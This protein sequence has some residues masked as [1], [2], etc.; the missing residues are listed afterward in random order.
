MSNTRQHPRSFGG[1]VGLNDELVQGSANQRVPLEWNVLLSGSSVGS[2]DG[3]NRQG[4]PFVCPHRLESREWKCIQVQ[5]ES[6][7]ASNRIRRSINLSAKH[8]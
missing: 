4:T 5:P 7:K 8:N 6:R 3:E 1:Q 2:S